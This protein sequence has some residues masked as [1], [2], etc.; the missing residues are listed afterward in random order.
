[1]NA[2]M[3][4]VEQFD[5]F[6]CVDVGVGKVIDWTGNAILVIVNSSLNVAR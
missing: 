2:K 5:F 1:M 3:D 4:E 6:S